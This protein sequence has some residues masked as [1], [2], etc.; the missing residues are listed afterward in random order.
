[1]ITYTLDMA[2]VLT[3]MSIYTS[4]PGGLVP[5][6]RHPGSSLTAHTH[7]RRLDSAAPLAE[8]I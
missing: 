7:I 8:T 5:L 6:I 4:L 2:R 1:M 3:L